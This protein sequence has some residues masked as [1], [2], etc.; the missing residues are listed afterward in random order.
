MALRLLIGLIVFLA[1]SAHAQVN[2]PFS[3]L[4]PSLVRLSERYTSY[5]AQRSTIPYISRDP[6]VPLVGDRVAI[7]A[8]AADD[9]NALTAE[10]IGLG[11]ADAVAFGRIVSGHLPIASIAALESLKSLR[12]ASPALALTNAGIVTTQGDIAMRSDVARTTFGTTGSGVTVGVLSDSYNCLGGAV[13]D[14]A[15]GDLPPVALL[16]EEPG[17]SSS[18]GTL[19]ISR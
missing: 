2:K 18:G 7:D 15:N 19:Y 12:F 1:S 6:L 9:V 13:L 17:C 4:S 14:I 10:L 8:T 3:Q 11:M 5:S 16:Q